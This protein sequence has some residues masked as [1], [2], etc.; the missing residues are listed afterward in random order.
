[1]VSTDNIRKLLASRRGFLA[2]LGGAI[3]SLLAAPVRAASGVRKVAIPLSKVEKLSKVGGWVILKIKGRKVLFVRQSVDRVRALDPTCTHEA[4]TVAYEP[5]SGKIR[6]PC[7]K[8]AYAL[9]G[10]VEAGPAPRPLTVFPAQLRGDRI[11]ATL[12]K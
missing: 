5:S 1:M 7:H 9:D 11:I 10:T 8:S 3:A 4:C 2:A 12:P 6:C